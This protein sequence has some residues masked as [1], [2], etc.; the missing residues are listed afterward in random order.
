MEH[1]TVFKKDS[2]LNIDKDVEEEGSPGALIK[3]RDCM[4]S[5]IIDSQPLNKIKSK[6]EQTN[7]AKIMPLD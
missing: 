7:E 4:K 3:N 2:P 5:P 6:E 1:Y